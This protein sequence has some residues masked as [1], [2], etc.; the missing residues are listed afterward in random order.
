MSLVTIGSPDGTERQCVDDA[1]LEAYPNWV[2][3]ASSAPEDDEAELVA[4]EWIVP[5]A[6]LQGR[7]WEAVKAKRETVETGTAPTPSG[8]V[9]IDEA[10]KVKI[11]GLTTMA[12]LAQLQAQTF[13]EDFT[14]ADNSVVTLSGA[15]TIA[16]GLAVG[17][18]ISAI[19]D[20]ARALREQIDAAT[21]A[22]DLDAIDTE[23]GWP[24]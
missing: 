24:E 9:Q 14:L 4:G 11:N 17:Q 20:N 23:A 6:V 12:M 22:A 3:L 1:Q 8:R 18:F 10:S 19:Y 13:S 15:E 7:K 21:S 5:L 16:M 2:L